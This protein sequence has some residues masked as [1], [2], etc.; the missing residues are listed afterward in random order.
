[1]MFSYKQ[2][3]FQIFPWEFV[4]FFGPILSRFY[5]SIRSTGEHTTRDLDQVLEVELINVIDD[6]LQQYI[7]N[8]NSLM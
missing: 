3:L 8:K 2:H 5:E 4:E 1:M 7:L 6:R